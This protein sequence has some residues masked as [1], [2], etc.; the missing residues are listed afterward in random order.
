M[1]PE[2]RRGVRAV[3]LEEEPRLR[4]APQMLLLLLPKRRGRSPDSVEESGSGRG[5][6]GR[7]VDSRSQEWRVPAGR[8]LAGQRGKSGAHRPKMGS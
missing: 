3:W 6:E 8:R 7:V 5:E 2:R 4:R 1:A